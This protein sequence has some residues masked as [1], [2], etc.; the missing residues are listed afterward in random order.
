MHTVLFLDGV[1]VFAL[2]SSLVGL[3][4]FYLSFNFVVVN[5]VDVCTF[6]TLTIFFVTIRLFF[7]LLGKFLQELSIELCY[8][9]LFKLTLIFCSLGLLKIFSV[10]SNL[11]SEFP[12]LI[13]IHGCLH[14]FFLFIYLSQF[15][16]KF[17]FQL[18]FIAFLY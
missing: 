16:I 4:H 5:F 11:N 8:L 10:L 14:E 18:L 17:I 6:F 13:E 1:P 3:D 12:N 2:F 15:F 9:L 7:G